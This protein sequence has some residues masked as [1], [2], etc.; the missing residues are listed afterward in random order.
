MAIFFST[1][2]AEIYTW[3]IYFGDIL[4]RANTYHNNLGIEFVIIG[5][6][7]IGDAWIDNTYA[8]KY[9]V[10]NLQSCYILKVKSFGTWYKIRRKAYWL[11]LYLFLMFS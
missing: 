3:G 7:I 5:D 9:F 6:T 10:M 8:I 2:F 1:S 4:K 11:P